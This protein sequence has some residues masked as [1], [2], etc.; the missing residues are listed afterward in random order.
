MAFC[1]Y[2][3]Y[4]ASLDQY[5]IGSTGNLEDRLY[6]HNNS[7]S[8]ATKKAKD[9]ELRYTESC[10]SRAEAVNREAEI[11]KK[12]SRHYIESLISSVG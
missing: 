7:G 5:Y 2:I 4:S 8:K 10:A 6:R 11:K 12:K 3:I 9:W 1:V